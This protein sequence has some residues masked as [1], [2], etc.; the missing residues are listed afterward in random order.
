MPVFLSADRVIL[1]T[2]LSW[3]ATNTE[4]Q[5]ALAYTKYHSDFVVGGKMLSWYWCEKTSFPSS[6]I[7]TN[8]GCHQQ[9]LVALQSIAVV[10][11][12]HRRQFIIPAWLQPACVSGFERFIC[13]FKNM[14]SFSRW[15]IG[16][17]LLSRRRN[18]FWL[19]LWFADSINHYSW[20]SLY[21]LTVLQYSLESCSSNYDINAS[22]PWLIYWMANGILLPCDW[23][24][25]L[26]LQ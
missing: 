1:T 21:M 11:P 5:I 17:M 7:L 24:H 22:F 10:H 2:V 26:I 12:S 4:D 20:F 25:L 19:F 6:C 9:Q 3:W 18:R 14:T 15:W 8:H 23:L 16:L 13:M